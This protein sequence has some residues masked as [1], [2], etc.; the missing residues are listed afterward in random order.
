[1]DTF[2]DSLSER[3]KDN[4]QFWADFEKISAKAISKTL[5]GVNVSDENLD[6]SEMEL[7]RLINAASIFSQSTLE[8]N[9]SLAQNIALYFAI[10]GGRESQEAAW[11]KK[12]FHDI[13]NHPGAQS[14]ADKLIPPE[15]D[16]ISY[17]RNRLLAKLNN[18]K[19]N[20]LD[21][22]LT[23]FQMDLWSEIQTSDAIAVSAPTSAGKSFVVLEYLA[24]QAIELNSFN[25]VFIA[26]TRALIGEVSDK[27]NNRLKDYQLKIRVSSIPTLDSDKNRNQIF[28][29]TQERLQVLLS[30]WAGS[31]DFVIVDEAQ[32]IGEDSRGMILQDCI[33][34]I[35][36]KNNKTKFVFLT[37]GAKGFEAFGKAINVSRIQVKSTD[38]SPV[39]Q[40]KIVITYDP[41]DENKI[42]LSLLADGKLIS[43]GGYNSERGFAN[44]DTRLSAVALELGR[45]GGSLVYG[46]GPA[47]AEEIGSGIAS[48]LKESDSPALKE[49]SKFIKEHI[50]PEYSLARHVVK[51]VGVHYGKMPSVLREALENAFKNADLKY[52]V[53]TTTL[54]QGVNLPARNVFINTPTRGRGHELE[55]AALW[56]FAGRAGRLGKDIIGN[57]FLVDY[58]D[59]KTQPL[60]AKA[61]FPIV[62]SFASTVVNHTDEVIQ[63]LKGNFPDKNEKENL[64]TGAATGLLLS[65]AA[66]G[67]LKEFAKNTLNEEVSDVKIDEIVSA[68]EVSL[69]ELDLPAEVLSLNWAVSPHGQSRLYKR[70]KEKIKSG[71]IDSLLPVSPS[72][73]TKVTH[74]RYTAI[75][76]RINKQIYGK[77]APKGFN[78]LLA[79]VS[80]AWMNGSP[81]PLII[82]KRIEHI[83]KTKELV[84]YDSEIRKTFEFIEDVL[85]FKYVQFGRA[86]ID[87]LRVALNEA[88][89]SKEASSIYD[90]PLSLEL[91]VSTQAGQVFIELGLSRVTASALENLIPHSNPSSTRARE[92][93]SSL[94]KNDIPISE[95]M[96]NELKVKGLVVDS[97]VGVDN[98]KFEGA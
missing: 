69:R 28:V 94:Q 45:L 8:Q 47:D 53:C 46:T 42:D 13:G 27:L 86:Y 52:L 61:H 80:L 16:F 29:L 5:S 83:R 14:L 88:G 60:S 44:A 37:P 95:V 87:L 4:D 79:S 9:K 25:A 21:Y 65:R 62:P 55:P 82:N 6:V 64:L 26:P 30:V 34:L 3:V 63:G 38:L 91:G 58:N 71:E 57:V 40:N 18:V 10:I 1:M 39:V 2:A 78:S 54:F 90:F 96:W 68:A 89:F 43:I 81:L 35:R 77:S 98:G 24:K 20:D 32:A 48:D 76:G 97:V 31:F 85:R 84:N 73:W 22:N 74:Q 59:W 41:S 12:I 66:R 19:I 70:I 49:L 67:T 36:S 50:H 56:N 15:V 72:P 92:W 7:K 33:E 75:F 11:A 23:D 93:L 17:L 51:G